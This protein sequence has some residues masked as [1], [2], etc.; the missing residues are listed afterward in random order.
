VRALSRKC[1]KTNDKLK[2]NEKNRAFNITFARCVFK[3]QFRFY[4]LL[5]IQILKEQLKHMI[6]KFSFGIQ[7]PV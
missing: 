6:M 2:Q 5:C 7:Q 1:K 4:N 3:M